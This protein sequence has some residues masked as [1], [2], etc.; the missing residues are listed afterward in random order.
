MLDVITEYQR[1]EKINKPWAFFDDL[2]YLFYKGIDFGLIELFLDGGRKY[3]KTYRACEFSAKATLIQPRNL[4]IYLMRWL[5]GDTSELNDELLDALERVLGRDL[6]KEEQNKTRKVYNINGN[7]FRVLGLHTPSQ[8]KKVKLTGLKRAKG[9]KYCIIIFEEAYEF[10][11][12]EIQ[13]IKEA[14]GGYKNYLMIYI[15][16][17][18]SLAIPFIKKREA[19]FPHNEKELKEKGFQFKQEKV[20]ANRYK[21]W[22]YGN[23]RINPYLEQADI[24]LILETW[25]TDP[26]RARVVDL[27]LPGIEQ[28]G[29]YAH[30]INKIIKKPLNW[31]L[32]QPIKS[33]TA[34]I[35]WGDGNTPEASATTCCIVATGYNN[36]TYILDTYKHQNYYDGYKSPQE[37]VADIIELIYQ[38]SKLRPDITYQPFNVYL[39]T[40]LH[41]EKEFL[42]LGKEYRGLE[43]L[44]FSFAT[45]Y[46]ER[47]RI[48]IRKYKMNTK[49]YYVAEHINNIIEELSLQTWDD[50]KKDKQNLPKQ[51]DEHNHLT[52]AEDYA[53]SDLMYEITQEEMFKLLNKW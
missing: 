47:T 46:Q 4:D 23:W 32:Q 2:L 24:E 49:R 16:N 50:T 25:N 14:I 40:G 45:K 7:E 37:R 34:G 44:N 31:I 18:N 6:N 13:Q 39:D 41:A 17:P 12:Q 22:F 29:I 3:G 27:G 28:N 20:R 10:T 8:R 9:K 5:K 15:T 42:E 30:E 51:K 48:N 36:E 35:D 52:D 43:W 19:E 33:I 38:F 21:M 11:E 26:A 53:L 1:L